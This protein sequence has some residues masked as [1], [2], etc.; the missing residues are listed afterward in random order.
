VS[1][2]N[3]AVHTHLLTVHFI[4]TLKLHTEQNYG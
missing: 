2:I 4:Q 1:Q 3:V